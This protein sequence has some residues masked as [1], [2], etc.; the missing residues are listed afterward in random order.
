MTEPVAKSL[1]EERHAHVEERCEMHKELIDALFTKV[2]CLI[3]NQGR[4]QWLLIGALIALLIDIARGFY[5]L[6]NVS[7]MVGR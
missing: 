4:I 1:C 3:K 7:K 5:V 2:D 6:D